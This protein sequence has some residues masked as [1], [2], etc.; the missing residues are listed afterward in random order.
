MKGGTAE[1]RW[2][3]EAYRDGEVSGGERAG[4]FEGEAYRNSRVIWI[5]VGEKG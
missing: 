2:K 1:R 3:W 5:N 4:R